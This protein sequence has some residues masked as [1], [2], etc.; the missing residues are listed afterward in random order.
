M[1]KQRNRY[2][3][4]K[5]LAVW[6]QLDDRGHMKPME[7]YLLEAGNVRNTQSLDRSPRQPLLRSPLRCH[8]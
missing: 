6:H 5:A 2:F 3:P 7:R 4:T 8:R 1:R